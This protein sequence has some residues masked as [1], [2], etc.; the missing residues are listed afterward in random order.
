[1]RKVCYCRKKRLEV[2]E[3]LVKRNLRELM[4][5]AP[6]DEEEDG[7][8]YTKIRSRITSV[9]DVIKD[10]IFLNSAYWLSE[11]SCKLDYKI[12]TLIAFFSL[13]APFWI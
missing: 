3:K 12:A 2:A 5:K 13:V 7:L 1:M 10:A 9:V 11:N 4:M 6:G 8:E